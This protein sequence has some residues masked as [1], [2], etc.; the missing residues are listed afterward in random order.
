MKIEGIQATSVLGGSFWTPPPSLG[1]T[2]TFRKSP[3]KSTLDATGIS[4]VAYIDIFRH[5]TKGITIQYYY[6]VYARFTH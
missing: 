2:I 3:K 5:Y 1:L 4:L 6:V